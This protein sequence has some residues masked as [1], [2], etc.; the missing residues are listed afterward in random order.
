MVSDAYLCTESLLAEDWVEALQVVNVRTKNS[1]AEVGIVTAL[2]F[3]QE[4]DSA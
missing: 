2:S 4:S 1:S 3:T